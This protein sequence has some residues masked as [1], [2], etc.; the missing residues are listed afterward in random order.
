MLDQ[1][2]IDDLLRQAADLRVRSAQVRAKADRV[3]AKSRDLIT[4]T[5]E[6]QQETGHAR[7]GS[8]NPGLISPARKR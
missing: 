8:R 1:H 7:P 6:V 4:W 3:I 2:R 5:R